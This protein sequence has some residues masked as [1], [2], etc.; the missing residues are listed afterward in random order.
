M[1]HFIRLFLCLAS[2]FPAQDIPGAQ[3]HTMIERFP[4]TDLTWQTIETFR[5]Y[6]LPFGPVTGYRS[7]SDWVDTEGRVTRSF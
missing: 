3:D 4:K 7:I 2:P 6:R 5:P 1:T